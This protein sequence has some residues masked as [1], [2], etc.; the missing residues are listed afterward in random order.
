MMEREEIRKQL[1]DLACE[2]FEQELIDC[3]KNLFDYS[4][5]AYQL[6]YFAIS[7]ENKFNVSSEKIFENTNYMFI[8]L[9]NLAEKIYDQVK[10]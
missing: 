1:L 5:D 9:D 7:I 2:N 8:T 10:E 3:S 4:V 6:L